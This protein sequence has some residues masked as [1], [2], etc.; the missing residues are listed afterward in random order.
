[1]A[2]IDKS[3]PENIMISIDKINVI[4]TNIMVPMD[5]C[6]PDKC[7]GSMD[8]LYPDKY[9]GSKGLHLSGQILLLQ[10]FKVI[11]TDIMVPI[12]KSNIDKYMVTSKGYK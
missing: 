7:N 10:R 3:Y 2:R 5:K 11:R 8:K 12:D 1:M 4:R 9:Y 6:H